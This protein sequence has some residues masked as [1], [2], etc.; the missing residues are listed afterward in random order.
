MGSDPPSHRSFHQEPEHTFC[1]S[2][3]SGP[4]NSFKNNTS[5]PHLRGRLITHSDQI[6]A[7]LFPPTTTTKCL[8]IPCAVTRV[9]LT[10]QVG[11]VVLFP[12]E[13]AGRVFHLFF[14]HPAAILVRPARLRIGTSEGKCYLSH[15]LDITC[16]PLQRLSPLSHSSP[17]LT[18][19]AYV[20]TSRRND[21]PLPLIQRRQTP[22]VAPCM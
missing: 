20:C 6:S 5:R 22:P 13:Y 9:C 1:P 10:A 14:P 21:L 18:H 15:D 12:I 19:G 11:H 16:D 17:K 8:R 3:R 2:T 7:C 4:F